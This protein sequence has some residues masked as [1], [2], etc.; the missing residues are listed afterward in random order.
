MCEWS[1]LRFMEVRLGEAIFQQA[2]RIQQQLARWHGDEYL[3]IE[4]KKRTGEHESKL[5]K[6]TFKALHH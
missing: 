6:A 4:E 1:K 3:Q 5:C 2:R